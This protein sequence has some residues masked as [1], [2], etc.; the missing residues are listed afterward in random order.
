MEQSINIFMMRAASFP[1]VMNNPMMTHYGEGGEVEQGV[2]AWKI[3][4][5]K[6]IQCFYLGTHSHSISHKDFSSSSPPLYIL[7]QS[8]MQKVLMSVAEPW[9]L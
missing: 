5:A 3:Y 4:A 2:Q 8:M 6:V 7:T 1:Y 9:T